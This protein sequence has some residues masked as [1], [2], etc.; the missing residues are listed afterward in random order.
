[1]IS[2]R[3]DAL[4]PTATGPNSQRSRVRYSPAPRPGGGEVSVVLVVVFGELPQSVKT[5]GAVF[6][7]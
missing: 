1:V 6:F 4:I 2:G 7:S 5:P 3:V